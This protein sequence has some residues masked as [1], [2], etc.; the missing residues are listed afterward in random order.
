M[1]PANTSRSTHLRLVG[2][3]VRRS[4]D[5]AGA[6]RFTQ[7][8]RSTQ[9]NTAGS[10]DGVPLSVIGRASALLGCFAT[11]G[12]TVT[13]AE[14]VRHTG[15]PKTTVH[16]LARELVAERFLDVA[17]GGYRLGLRL[18]ELGE[19]VPRHRT[20]REAAIPFMEDLRAAT[21]QRVHLAVLDGVDVVYV[22]ILGTGGMPLASRTGGRLPA[23]AT[24]VGKAMLAFAPAAV[25]R[26]RVDAGLTRHTPR[27]IITPGA[28]ATEL[29]AIR[30]EGLAF[31]REES[32]VGVSC[33]AAPV[34][35]AVVAGGE[36]VGDG[37][38]ST[39]GVSTVG[40]STVGMSTVGA[41]TM[42][43]DPVGAGT[44][45][46]GQAMRGTV[47]VGAISVTGPT[48]RIDP[49]RLGPAVRTAA[50]ALTRRLGGKLPME[51]R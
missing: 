24:G 47:V 34:F 39:V 6:W 5:N 33:V 48:N 20:L 25:V 4:L 12:P 40:V 21:R 43:A 36:R 16:R 3:C 17:P 38:A 11:L 27:T 26:A 10:R 29:H 41:S 2:H 28:L 35:G 37:A 18:F 32:H 14:L 50:L 45:S 1:T 15:L 44:L 42:G 8:M 31:D 30:A 22:E 19:L 7:L 9:R 46:G 23:H 13:L 49:E 51:P